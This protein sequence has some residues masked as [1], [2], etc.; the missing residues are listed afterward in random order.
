MAAPRQTKRI[1][2]LSQQVAK[3]QKDNQELRIANSVLHERITLNNE[4]I[5][6]LKNRLRLYQ[7][8]GIMFT[9]DSN[10]FVDWLIDYHNDHITSYPQVLPELCNK[11]GTTAYNINRFIKVDNG[12]VVIDKAQY[13]RYIGGII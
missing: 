8:G 11:I 3:E 9:V 7:Q 10:G 6:A 2:E 5:L 13:E 1:I 12:E 4:E